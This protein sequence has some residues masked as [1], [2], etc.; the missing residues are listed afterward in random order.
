MES[1]T[2]FT[3]RPSGS[4]HRRQQPGPVT[5]IAIGREGWAVADRRVDVP[6]P[7]LVEDAAE[8]LRALVRSE[9]GWQPRIVVLTADGQDISTEFRVD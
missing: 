5:V 4:R 9:H 2:G 1:Q 6:L 3:R 8:Q 7:T